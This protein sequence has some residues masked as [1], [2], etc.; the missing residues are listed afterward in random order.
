METNNIT[1]EQ[2]AAAT[3]PETQGKEKKPPMSKNKKI[4]IAIVAVLVC[5]AA[6][7]FIISGIQQKRAEDEATRQSIINSGVLHPG[8]EIQGIAVGGMTPEEAQSALRV[9]EEALLEEISFQL[10]MQDDTIPVTAADVGAVCNTASVIA[11]A[12]QLGREGS[13][14]ELQEELLDIETNKRTFSLT[15]KAT[16]SAVKAFVQTLADEY[17]ALPTN[18]EYRMLI[19]L[20]THDSEEQKDEEFVVAAAATT[21]EQRMEYVADAPGI[22]I[23]QADLTSAI[24]SMVEAKSYHDYTVIFASTDAEVTLA[25]I[26]EQVV[27]RGAAST[28]FAKSPY[29]R[30]TRMYNIQK[31]VSLINGTVLQPGEEFSTNGALGYRTYAAGW[32]P[33]P[34][35]VQGRS[36]DQAGGGVCQVSSTLYNCVLYADLEIVYRQGHSARLSYIDGGLDATID[37]GRIDFKWKNNTSSPLY[38]YGWVNMDERRVFFEI[39]GEPFP[40]E[41]DSIQLSS[42]RIS[43][44][45][46]PGE[47]QYVVDYTKPSGY[48][49]VFVARKSGSLWQSYKTYL[50]DGVAVKTETI[51]NTTYKAYAGQTIVGP[52]AQPSTPASTSRPSDSWPR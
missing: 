15:Y 41:Y 8:I 40:E 12:M 32:K 38:I 9:A 5:A 4:I 16:E 23:D 3:P 51:D 46:P 7:F 34:A 10:T 19:D 25:D 13:L 1:T 29:N 28:S 26:Q 21:P 48:S 22:Q 42:K 31:A 37:S 18:A 33:A 36:E 39:Y 50:K 43:S 6:A 2:Q 52:S 49:Q 24:I 11:E 17:D 30:S 44:I 20:K 27:L 47:M 35:I 45:S 14:K